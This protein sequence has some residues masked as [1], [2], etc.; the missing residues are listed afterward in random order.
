LVG[1]AIATLKEELTEVYGDRFEV[2][3]TEGQKKTGPASEAKPE[4][5]P[6]AKK[7]KGE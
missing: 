6:E 5:K 3:Q 1:V 7:T 4:A 2:V